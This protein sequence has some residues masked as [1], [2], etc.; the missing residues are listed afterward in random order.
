MLVLIFGG[1]LGSFWLGLAQGFSYPKGFRAW[2]HVKSMVIE[3]GHPLYET[4]GGQH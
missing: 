4:F 2:T 1:L 3:P